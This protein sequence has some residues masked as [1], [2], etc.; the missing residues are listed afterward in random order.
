MNTTTKYY[1]GIEKEAVSLLQV[2]LPKQTNDK[3]LSEKILE[4][5][6]CE[7]GHK[8][9]AAAFQEFCRN[10]PL[11]DLEDSTL[12]EIERRLLDA[13][14]F[15]V[16]EIKP[17]HHDG[18]LTVELA[19]PSGPL[20]SSI[21][22]NDIPL[23]E[24]EIQPEVKVKF[25]PFPVALPGDPEMVWIFAKSETMTNDEAARALHEAQVDFWES[26]SGQLQLRK[27]ADRTFPEF[28]KRVPAGLLRELGLKRHYKDPEVKKV[29]RIQK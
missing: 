20:I 22:I 28:A 18:T 14:G 13:F 24:D 5:F 29:L 10:C 2:V 17:N 23:N 19:T 7:I 12:A 16:G 8:K 9:Q 26:R 21:E 25:V 4:G 3:Q 11:P 6:K 15:V 1:A 27:G